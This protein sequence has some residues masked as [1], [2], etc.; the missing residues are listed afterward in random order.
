MRRRDGTAQ[1]C[2][3]T[4]SLLLAAGEERAL[5]LTCAFTG[6]LAPSKRNDPDRL[7]LEVVRVANKKLLA[8]SDP[9]RYGIEGAD[10]DRS[11]IRI[12]DVMLA[13][14]D[15]GDRNGD[16]YAHARTASFGV[17]LANDGLDAAGRELTAEIQIETAGNTWATCGTETVTLVPT[18]A[19]PA[20]S[21]AA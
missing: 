2:A 5:H 1:Q 15:G 13:V 16:G 14:A 9:Q 19:L 4:P 12:E 11:V 21:P 17:V 6:G 18:T 20:A 8:Q 7:W 3:R 10:N